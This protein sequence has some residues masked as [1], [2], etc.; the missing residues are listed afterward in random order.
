[1]IS[2]IIERTSSIQSGAKYLTLQ[3]AD[4]SSKMS[5]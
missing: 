2:F 5:M 1:M 3:S 4:K